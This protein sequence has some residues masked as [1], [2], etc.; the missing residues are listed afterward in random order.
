MSDDELNTS[1]LWQRPGFLIRR[2]NQI[3]HAIFNET[4]N[5]SITPPLSTEQAIEQPL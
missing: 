4:L 2:L 3:H 1:N 5:G